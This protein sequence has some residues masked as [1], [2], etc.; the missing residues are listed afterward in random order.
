MSLVPFFTDREFLPLDL[1]AAAPSSG[2]HHFDGLRHY[3]FAD[4][5]SEQDSNFQITP[6]ATA[7]ASAAPFAE[8]NSPFVWEWRRQ[9]R[10]GCVS[11][12]SMRAGSAIELFYRNPPV[13][14]S[15]TLQTEAVSASARP[16]AIAEV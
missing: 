10:Y 12:V 11:G 3:L 15:S 5:V 4:V 9:Q 1:K 14:S 6:P 16:S 8:R 2:F 13:I 7:P